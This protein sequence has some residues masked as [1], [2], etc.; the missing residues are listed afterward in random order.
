MTRAERRRH[1]RRMKAKARRIRPLNPHAEKDA[2]HLASCSCPLCGNPRRHFGDL[3]RQEILADAEPSEVRDQ[4][5]KH[6][7][8]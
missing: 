8:V 1:A 6:L 4:E 5:R 2:D 7:R 3:T